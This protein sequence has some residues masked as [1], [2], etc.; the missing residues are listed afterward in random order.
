MWYI[1]VG[2]IWRLIL[3]ANTS[4]IAQLSKYIVLLWLLIWLV[5]KYFLNLLPLDI[6]RHYELMT[7]LLYKIVFIW[8]ESLATYTDSIIFKDRLSGLFVRKA[9]N[10][11]NSKRLTNIKHTFST[12]AS[13]FLEAHLASMLRVNL[14]ET[15]NVITTFVDTT[16]K[17]W[18]LGLLTFVIIYTYIIRVRKWTI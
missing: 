4:T 15:L 8:M 6:H 14:I 3:H 7:T 12:S 9:F 11:S 16:H 5:L 18:V 13:L 1:S 2:C 17:T 10:V